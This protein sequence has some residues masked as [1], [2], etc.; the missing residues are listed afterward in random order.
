[1][2]T[3]LKLLASL[4]L[5]FCLVGVPFAAD[6]IR[7]DR[8]DAAKPEPEKKPEKAPERAKPPFPVE[9]IKDIPYRDDKYA[10]GNK[11]RLDLYL[12]KGVNRFP[13]IFFVHGGSWK[14]GDKDEYPKLGE[15][16]ATEGL[17][18]VVISYRLSP[19][20]QHPAHIEDV[21]AAFSWTRSKID[22]YG[23]RND[24]IFVMGHSAGG[25]LAA[26]LATDERYLKNEG[27]RFNDVRGVI[28]LSGVHTISPLLPIYRNAFGKDRDDCRQASP[29]THVGESHPPFMLYYAD[30]DLPTLGKM[31]EDLCA[32]LKK[33]K[34][35]AECVKV[36]HRNHMTI[37]T[38]LMQEDDPVKFG[39][40]EFIAKHS[41]WKPAE[42]DDERRR[43]LHRKDD[44]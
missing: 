36:P 44:K 6:L 11:H 31:S 17:G 35:E 19:K 12:P 3:R 38:D 21:A 33:N 27:L 25:H 42:K 13:V 1:M 18:V 41:E 24:R 5:A 22:R 8:R 30:H 39:I 14:S 37:L 15:T 43:L 16:F 9:T 28:A 40:F 26:L 29:I 34:G 20:V 7:R 4:A 2:K 32:M 23:G 10:D